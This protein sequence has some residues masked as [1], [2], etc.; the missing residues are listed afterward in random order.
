VTGHEA[1][2]AA[3]QL[4]GVGNAD[5]YAPEGLAAALRRAASLICPTS[6]R[7]LVDRCSDALGQL[8]QAPGNVRD[9]LKQSLDDLLSVGDLVE[10]VSPETEG[11]RLYLRTPSFVRLDDQHVL[12]LGVRPDAESLTTSTVAEGVRARGA[13][14]LLRL[15]G[16]QE[17]DLVAE[18]LAQLKRASWLGQPR[19]ETAQAVFERYMERIL[20]ATPV[21]MPDC[22]II[23]GAGARLFK[24]RFRSPAPKDDGL[25]V[26]RRQLRYGARQW[27]VLLL[28]PGEQ[29]RVLDLPVL[30]P[31]V[32]AVD[33]ARRLLAACDAVDGHPQ[34]IRITR[35]GHNTCRLHL[36]APLPFWCERYLLAIGN[37]TKTRGALVTY[38]VPVEAC[39][40]CTE[41]LT[42]NLWMIVE[43]QAT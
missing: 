11:F 42:A 28:T 20:A 43:G 29:P 3:A 39:V 32:P 30:N 37:A 9:L 36:D 10:A 31:G 38:E 41:F 7:S 6:R 34:R 14:R 27:C 35:D 1:V 40:S 22:E 21:D 2:G 26:G 24:G 4:L 5:L 16:D 25:F 13:L 8:P 12:L 23:D 17:Q 18:G 15:S 33:E 19:Q